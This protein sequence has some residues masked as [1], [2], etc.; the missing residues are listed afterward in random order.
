MARTAPVALP[1]N[2]LDKL[3]A[4]VAPG[5]AIK[6]AA[7]RGA[8]ALSGGYT[9]ARIDRATLARYLPTSGSADA[10][11][12]RDLP[13]LR[14]R[15]SDQMRNSPVAVGAL[16]Q[17]VSGT[18]GTGLSHAAVLDAAFLGLTQDQADA[19]QA[20][21]N[22]RYLAWSE[23]RDC[24]VARKLD[25][26]AQQALFWRSWQEKGDC[27]ALTPMVQRPGR[28]KQLAVQLIEAERVCN[29]HHKPNTH[30]LVDGIEL[31]PDTREALA[32]HF[33]RRHP[34]DGAQ[35]QT[36]ERREIRGSKTGR[37]NVLH[38]MAQLRPGQTRGVPW[39]A[40]ILEPLKQLQRW[41][42]AE[43]NAAVV[44]G[45]MSVF[46]KMDPNA[47]QDIFD[48]DAQ[49]AIV[50]QASKW[51]GEME[52]GQ[53]INLLPGESIEAPTPGRPNPEFDPFWVAMVRQ[54]G[55]ALEVPY[56]V[57]TMHFQSSYSAARGAMLMAW[58]FFRAKRDLLAKEFCQPIYETWL[59]NEVAEGR[60]RAPG[61]FADDVVRA[62]WCA[63]TWTGDGPGSIDPSKEVA[64]AKQRVALGISTLAAES[65][66]HDGEDW[67]AKH[68]QRV[69]EINAQKRDGIWQPEPGAPAV[70]EEEHIPMR[71]A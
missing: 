11:I 21:T 59:L 66:L 31:H 4:Y 3:I 54:I 60:I 62:A 56:E 65:I 26:Y 44:S 18:V 8:L 10:E 12:I 69:R 6:R 34:G 51:S 48:E 71:N 15:S 23:S 17:S 19:W 37:F 70:I 67:E 43:L 27:F 53:A 25:M 41:T 58:K 20:D 46:I 63:G 40:P 35:G 7:Q 42:D 45:L 57:L 52:S 55:M 33:A 61:I 64:A 36:W 13:M 9:G 16:N 38:G 49:G 5:V 30:T 28:P 39:I 1:Q 22:R 24:D 50:D 2:T 47:F 32:V 14:A 68:R 29:P